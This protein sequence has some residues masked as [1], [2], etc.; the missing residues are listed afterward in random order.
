MSQRAEAL[1]AKFEQANNDVIAAV[2]GCSDGQW[3]ATCEAEAWPVSVTAHHIAGGYPLIAGLA[4]AMAG[5]AQFPPLTLDVIDKGNADHARQFASVSKQD[6]LAMLKDS[7]RAA[8][9]VVRGLSDEQL[10]KTA[11][12]L[13]GAPEMNTEQMIEA[14]LIGSAVGHLAS[15][16]KAI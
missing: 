8:A 15:I 14:V 1:A 9:G 13:A 5:G 2:E 10:D 12:V 7:G 6:T 11:V 3:S 16:R 4:Q